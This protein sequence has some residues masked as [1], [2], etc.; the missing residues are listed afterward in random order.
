M[1]VLPGIAACRV[2]APM[3]FANVQYIHERLRK[4]VGRATAYS[5]AAGVELQYLLLDMSPVTHLDSTG[6]RQTHIYSLLRIILGFYA[7]MCYSRQAQPLCLFVWPSLAVEF[8]L[9]DLLMHLIAYG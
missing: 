2:D 3:Y 8:H 1:Q 9:C 6:T 7:A 5:E 4:Y